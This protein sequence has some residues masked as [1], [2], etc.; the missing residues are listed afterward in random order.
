[1]ADG[2]VGC[3]LAW[4]GRFGF[5]E[6]RRFAQVVGVQFLLKGLIGGLGEHRFFFKDGEDTHRLYHTNRLDRVW[7]ETE[8][9][10]LLSVCC[11]NDPVNSLHIFRFHAPIFEVYNFLD[12]LYDNTLADFL[13]FNVP[14]ILS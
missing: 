12:K 6:V 13:R 10:Y 4:L 9:S 14:E 7:W 3:L 1:M 11:L 2:E 5:Q 8:Y